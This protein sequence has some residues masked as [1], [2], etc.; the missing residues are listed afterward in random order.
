MHIIKGKQSRSNLKD[1]QRLHRGCFVPDPPSQ[2]KRRIVIQSRM[3]PGRLRTGMGEGHG[4]GD[5]DAR[6]ELQQSFYSQFLTAEQAG[7]RFGEQQVE[8]VHQFVMGIIQI[9]FGRDAAAVRV[10]A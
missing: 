3:D 5:G 10:D 9:H 1:I 8:T 7:D 2:R 4:P 6:L